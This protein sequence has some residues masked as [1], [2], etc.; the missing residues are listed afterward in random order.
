M[1]K[2]ATIIKA[3]FFKTGSVLLDV[4]GN[5]ETFPIMA[6]TKV[7]KEKLSGGK[8]LLTWTTGPFISNKR[9]EIIDRLEE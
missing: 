1:M 5:M 8:Y 4:D 6:G 7:K 2:K 3:G 9:C